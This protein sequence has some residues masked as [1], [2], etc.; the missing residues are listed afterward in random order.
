MRSYS[1]NG[2]EFP[3]VTTIIH[4]LG[5]ERLMTWANIMGFKRRK[6]SDILDESSRFGTI[7]HEY[8]RKII[9]P[10]APNPQDLTLPGFACL[11]ISDLDKNVRA[12]A[13]KHQITPL[14]TEK[15]MISEKYGYGGT[16]DAFGSIFFDNEMHDNWL[17]DWKT[18]KS[19]HDTMWLQMGGY[20]LLLKEY[21]YEANGASILQISD[22]RCKHSHINKDELNAYS[23]AFLSL[24]DFYKFWGNRDN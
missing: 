14:F 5:S 23:E 6:I 7:A 12:F 18:A 10:S 15:E 11:R 22:I 4:I 9:D 3:S 19:V 24:L 16:C 8:A 13:I 2:K 1:I 20:N 21:G 17:M